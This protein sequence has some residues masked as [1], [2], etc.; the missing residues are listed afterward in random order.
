MIN[1]SKAKDGLSPLAKHS[2]GGLLAHHRGLA[3]S[4]RHRERLQTPAPSVPVGILGQLGLRPP[5]FHHSCPG[6]SAAPVRVSSTVSV[7]RGRRAQRRR[8]GAAGVRGSV[9]SRNRSR[10]ARRRKRLDTIDATVGVPPS[11]ADALDA[12]EADTT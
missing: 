4:A 5:R 6:L 2:I 10:Q 8:R 11:L 12:L 9:S 1:D 7:R 3:G